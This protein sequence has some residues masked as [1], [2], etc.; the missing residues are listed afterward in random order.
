MRDRPASAASIAATTVVGN[1]GLPRIRLCADVAR[2]A[3][4]FPFLSPVLSNCAPSAVATD[5]DGTP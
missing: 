4:P 5:I 1:R 3:P 2:S